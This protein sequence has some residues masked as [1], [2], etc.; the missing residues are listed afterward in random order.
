ME[1][2][3]QL[4]PASQAAGAYRATRAVALV[5]GKSPG[6]LV[7]VLVEDALDRLDSL[8]GAV[9]FGNGTRAHHEYG[10]ISDILASLRGALDPLY[11]S[12]TIDI[13][14]IYRSVEMLAQQ[15]LREDRPDACQDAKALLQ[16]I[17]T[18]WAALLA[19]DG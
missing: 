19:G 15:A 16:P 13:A 2:H 9:R 10:R 1:Q 6:A 12:I 5:E 8:A 3:R 7:V 14:R 11:G 17:A 4:T 18:T